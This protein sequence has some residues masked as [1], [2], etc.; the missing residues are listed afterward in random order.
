MILSK[1]PLREALLTLGNGYFGTR[2]AAQ[3]MSANRVHYPGVYIAGVW[4]TLPTDVAGRTIYNEDFVNAP[5]WL[6][7]IYRIGDGPWFNRLNMKILSYKIELNLQK[8][9]LSRRVRWKDNEGRVTLEE[10]HR[11]VSMAHP[12][13]GALKCTIT[14]ENYD[15]GNNNS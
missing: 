10:S 8:G 11:I 1:I 14:P 5:N 2:G 7:L 13:C 4:N 3:E 12:H 6:M 9:M 15:G